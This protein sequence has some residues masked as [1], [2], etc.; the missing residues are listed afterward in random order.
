MIP[1]LSQ[2][3]DGWCRRNFAA[4]ESFHLCH[5]RSVTRALARALSGATAS[6]I[7]QLFIHENEGGLGRSPPI[8]LV[9]KLKWF[10]F[11]PTSRSS[12]AAIPAKAGTDPSGFQRE[13]RRRWR[14]AIQLVI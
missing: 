9:Y 7:H 1:M 11:S 8:A 10:L 4:S 12:Q 2:P 3:A 14:A 6:R 5:R 13:A